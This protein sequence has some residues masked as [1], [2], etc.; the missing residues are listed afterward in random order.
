M[1]GTGAAILGAAVLPRAGSHIHLGVLM[2]SN[3]TIA[4]FGAFSMIATATMTAHAQPKH[5][6]KAADTDSEADPDADADA[7]KPKTKAKA[8]AKR[9]KAKAKAR[10]MDTAS[11]ADAE[12]E[13]EREREREKE[14]EKEK[15]RE[16]E[17]ERAREKEAAEAEA[18]RDKAR[19]KVTE[20]ASDA[21][22]GGGG[23][24]EAYHSGTLG[25]SIPFTVIG[26]ATGGGGAAGEPVPTVDVV[27]FLDDKAA[28]DLIVGINLH[29]RHSVGAMGAASDSTLIGAAAGLGYR[30]YSSKNGLRSFLEPQAVIRWPDTSSTDALSVNVGG[31]FGLERN[32]TPWFSVSGAVGVTLNFASTFKDIQLASA[33]TLAAN[34]YWR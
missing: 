14:K 8:K 13:A 32:L 23:G 1:S 11:D 20:T 33:A 5:H 7:P 34:L 30:M 22:S 27:Y 24:G 26:A 18:A 2:F 12:A 6:A 21:T 25:F 19:D 10:D 9:G 17:R 4:A 31:L 3:R 15:E 29:R 16:A 28:L